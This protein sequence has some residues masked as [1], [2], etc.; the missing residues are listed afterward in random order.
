[1]PLSNSTVLFLKLH[2][3]DALKNTEK[4][5]RG[6]GAQQSRN[7]LKEMMFSLKLEWEETAKRR[8]GRSG[9]YLGWENSKCKAEMSEE[10][11]KVNRA[12]SVWA[13]RYWVR[14]AFTETCR[15]RAMEHPVSHGVPGI[16][17]WVLWK[18]FEQ[19]LWNY[20]ASY[21]VRPYQEVSNMVSERPK[22][23]FESPALSSYALLKQVPL[24][25]IMN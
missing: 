16:S 14:D 11:Q 3:L 19:R 10:K 15:G 4:E 9:K 1:M 5:V 12:R 20:W 22:H 8:W 21:N 7:T 2:Q 25:F 13:E 24:T 23:V 18:G 17:F 6:K